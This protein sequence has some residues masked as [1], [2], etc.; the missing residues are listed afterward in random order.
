MKQSNDPVLVASIGNALG[1]FSECL[2]DAQVQAIA[3]RLV[4]WMKKSRVP[5]NVHALVSAFGAF[6][7]RLSA[8]Q[9][10][11]IAE[12]IEEMLE[13]TSDHR[14]IYEAFDLF[15]VL[16]TLPIPPNPQLLKSVPD[17]LQFPDTVGDAR[18]SLL[19]YYSRAAG[20]NFE[21]SDALVAWVREH[22]PDLD[23]DRPPR[24]PF[25]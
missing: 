20:E 13:G 7:K 15:V 24:N 18:E 23:L 11:A 21:T 1:A 16:D 5:D 22:R 2:T 6:G 4:G 10:Q 14:P 25:R 12:R 19:R 8:T 9:A 3:E 17:L